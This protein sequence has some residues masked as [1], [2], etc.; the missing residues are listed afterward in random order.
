MALTRDPIFLPINIEE[1][2]A[3]DT[4]AAPAKTVSIMRWKRDEAE[5]W[6]RVQHPSDTWIENGGAFDP[7]TANR[8]VRWMIGVTARNSW[9][10]NSGRFALGEANLPSATRD[11]FGLTE[12]DAVSTLICVDLSDSNLE[13]LPAPETESVLNFDPISFDYTTTGLETAFTSTFIS[14]GSQ[15]QTAYSGDTRIARGYDF[16]CSLFRPS[17]F[18]LPA[19]GILCPTNGV[20]QFGQ[21]RTDVCIGNAITLV[22]QCGAGWGFHRGSQVHMQVP[23]DS[24]YGFLI[25]LDNGEPVDA[26]NFLNVPPGTFVLMSAAI[27]LFPSGGVALAPQSSLFQ[28]G[29]NIYAREAII[30]YLGP[31]VLGGIEL[32]LNLV[33]CGEAFETEPGPIDVQVSVFATNRD[34]ALATVPFDGDDQVRFCDPSLRLV[35]TYDWSFGEFFECRSESCARIFFPY[36]PKFFETD[37]FAGFSYVNHG[38]GDLATVEASIYESDGTHWTVDMGNLPLRQQ[39][40]YLIGEVDDA[41]VFMQA[42][43]DSDV[44]IPSNDEGDLVFGDLRSSMFLVGCVIDEDGLNAFGADLDGYLLIG[45]GDNI[46]GSY[47]SRNEEG[48][49]YAD[50]TGDLPVLFD[51]AAP[52]YDAEAA[53]R[54]IRQLLR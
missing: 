18:S 17:K 7:P 52:N 4:V 11:L 20:A 23:A 26:S 28:L 16:D 3:G 38:M 22:A 9:N 45:A 25:Q 5:I 29:I 13:P 51:K 30:E 2:L 19:R 32:N 36:L 21:E 33:V 31:G 49:R 10:E 53:W 50:Q 8:R 15:V 42:E 46:N 27:N 14:V 48:V 43:D 54:A 44:R 1:K 24:D 40:T 41:V 39:R 35:G 34:G 37:F 6:L 47:L 12:L